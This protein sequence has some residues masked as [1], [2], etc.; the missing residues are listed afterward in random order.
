MSP[1]FSVSNARQ[2]WPRHHD[3]DWRAA[4]AAINRAESGSAEIPVICISPFIEAKPPVW[5]PSYPLPGFLYAYLSVY[6][7]RGK[8]YL[9]PFDDSP[10]AT[11]FAATLS[12]GVLLKSRRF[13][14]YGWGPQVR[15]WHEW[16][17]GRP[18]FSNWRERTLGPFADVDVVEFDEPSPSQ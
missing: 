2:L 10:P 15:Y 3:S 4:A 7:I 14:I 6:P 12:N 13:L 17:A 1:C 18:Q 11:S 9:F 16:F 5:T 8:V